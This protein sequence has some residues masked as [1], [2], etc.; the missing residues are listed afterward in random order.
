VL[1]GTLRSAPIGS[2]QGASRAEPV[3]CC[4]LRPLRLCSEHEGGSHPATAREHSSSPGPRQGPGLR[5]LERGWSTADRQTFFHESRPGRR[6]RRFVWRGSVAAASS[7]QVRSPALASTSQVPKRNI[8]Y[9]LE[10]RKGRSAGP[11]VGA[12][13]AGRGRAG[14]KGRQL[15]AA[16]AAARRPRI[17]FL[18]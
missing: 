5:W 18:I 14:P 10:K 3:C 9:F 2:G 12:A 4:L 1:G 7:P 15:G 6:W 16:A 8:F 13:E 11:M 17:C